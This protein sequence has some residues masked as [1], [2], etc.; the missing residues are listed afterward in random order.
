VALCSIGRQAVI[1]SEAAHSG[2]DVAHYSSKDTDQNMHIDT[3]TVARNRAAKQVTD[4]LET[5]APEFDL[6]RISDLLQKADLITRNQAEKIAISAIFPDWLVALIRTEPVISASASERIC[7]LDAY[8]HELVAPKRANVVSDLVDSFISGTAASPPV[9]R[10]TGGA[11]A[12]YVHNFRQV[13]WGDQ[14]ILEGLSTPNGIALSQFLRDAKPRVLQGHTFLGVVEGSTIYTHWLLDTLPRLLLLAEDGTDFSEFDNF[15]FASI[16]SGFH[17]ATLENL[18]IGLD[19]V[20]T[21]QHDGGLFHVD[22][23]TH[24][25]AP[26]GSFVTHPRIYE[27]VCAHFGMRETFSVQPAKQP[28]R[29]F[30]SRAKAGRR[31]ILNEDAVME[32]LAPLGFQAICLEDLSIPETAQMIARASHIIAPHGAGLANLVF[33]RAGTRVLEL[34]NAH[35]SR[36]YWIICNHKKLD[37]HAF[38]VHGPDQTYLDPVTRNEISFMERNGLDLSVPLKDFRDYVRDVFL[39]N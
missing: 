8:R 19:R 38:E 7:L 30:I 32:L 39:E 6:K 1:K 36:E 17:K 14:G 37:Y 5:T 26:R 23:F 13:A 18:G 9:I 16:Q 11:S 22:S 24:V 15:L 20:V 31:R 21:R 27:M 4:I 34:F 3:S 10:I 33:A 29:L 28:L 25:T 2:A 35:L 12:H